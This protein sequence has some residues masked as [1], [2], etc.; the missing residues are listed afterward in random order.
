MNVI[1]EAIALSQSIPAIFIQRS[2][3]R[4]KWQGAS[5]NQRQGHGTE[6]WQF[7][8]YTCGDSASAIDWRQSARFTSTLIKNHEEA[9]P[10]SL[11]ICLD[12][13]NTMQFTTTNRTKQHQADV[14]ALAISVAIS[15][16]G[17]WVISIQGNPPKRYNNILSI[18]NDLTIDTPINNVDIIPADI[19]ILCSDFLY[20]ATELH[21]LITPIKT[22]KLI[23]FSFFDTAEKTLPYEGRILFNDLIGKNNKLVNNVTTLRNNY[24]EL[25]NQHFNN[26]INLAKSILAEIHFFNTDKQI[27]DLYPISSA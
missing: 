26:L 17:D 4:L 24:C 6:F 15:N 23:L 2:N 14:V 8:P 25:Y 20:P 12:R 11:S 21:Q 16:M 5:L 1:K 22:E 19:T 18:Y 13:R 27:T 7:R 9:S 10:N 3:S